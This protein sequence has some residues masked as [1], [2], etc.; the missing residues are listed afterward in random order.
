MKTLDVNLTAAVCQTKLFVHYARKNK[1]PGWKRVMASSSAG[2][3]RF[4][5]MPLHSAAK[6]G[7]I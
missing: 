5:V 1:I 7:V 2:L 4:G 3:Y 6:H